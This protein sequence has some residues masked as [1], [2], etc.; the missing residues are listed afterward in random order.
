MHAKLTL[1]YRDGAFTASALVATLE[2]H[3]VRIHW[4]GTR[5]ELAAE[6]ESEATVLS[7]IA[8]GA[9]DQIMAGVA[10]FHQIAPQADVVVEANP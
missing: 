8:S 9:P 7:V 5:E 10:R 4:T 2:S 3:G 6:A 1:R